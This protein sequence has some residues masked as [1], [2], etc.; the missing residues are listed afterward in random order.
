MESIEHIN[1]KKDRRDF[2][3]ELIHYKFSDIPSKFLST[4]E[5]LDEKRISF[6]SKRTFGTR[7]L[8][9]LFDGL[10]DKRSTQI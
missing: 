7:T 1:M 5:Q 6:L 4:V 10:N 3:I 9:E 2:L 8:E